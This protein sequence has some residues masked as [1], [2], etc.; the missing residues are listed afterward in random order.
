MAGGGIFS[1]IF[2]ATAILSAINGVH[3]TP[4]SK[5]IKNNGAQKWVTNAIGVLGE[6]EAKFMETSTQKKKK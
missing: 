3:V 1:F 6:L 5:E 4:Y 2:N